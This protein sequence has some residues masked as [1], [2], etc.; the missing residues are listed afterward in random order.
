MMTR[1]GERREKKQRQQQSR[2]IS[3]GGSQRALGFVSI[4]QSVAI[5]RSR[6]SVALLSRAATTLQATKV[7]KIRIG[8]GFK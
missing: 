2:D 3:R 4:P 6:L 8:R 1:D 7:R 5:E